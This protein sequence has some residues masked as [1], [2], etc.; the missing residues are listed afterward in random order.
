MPDSLFAFDSGRVLNSQELEEIM[1]KIDC[2]TS[3]MFERF[4]GK[5]PIEVCS[6]TSDQEALLMFG[7]T[8]TGTHNRWSHKDLEKVRCPL[9]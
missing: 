7:L 4:E 6:D 9:H 5:A 8:A 1:D 3:R 2:P